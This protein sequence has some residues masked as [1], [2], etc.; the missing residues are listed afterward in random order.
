MFEYNGH[1]WIKVGPRYEDFCVKGKEKRKMDFDV[2]ISSD[3]LLTTLNENE[4]RKIV[5]MFDLIDYCFTIVDGIEIT[6]YTEGYI[7]CIT[8]SMAIHKASESYKMLMEEISHRDNLKNIRVEYVIEGNIRNILD[9]PW[10][11]DFRFEV[12]S[13]DDGGGYFGYVKSFDRNE[14]FALGN[15]LEETARNLETVLETTIRNFIK[16]GLVIPTPGFS[17]GD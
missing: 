17:E 5:T 12:V 16:E 10:V 7:F 6:E 14:C 1:E 3:V 11:N 9:Q 4:A 15:T 13:E 2:K 8:T